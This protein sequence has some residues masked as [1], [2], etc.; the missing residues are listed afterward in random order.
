[1]KPTMKATTRRALD[2]IDDALADYLKISGAA[3]ETLAS[4]DGIAFTMRLM[5][6]LSENWQDCPVKRCR[7]ARCCQGPDMVCQ[8]DGFPRLNAPPA[9]IARANARMR[10]V[11]VW[12]LEGFGLL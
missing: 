3:P 9:E 6:D 8:L 10:R 5:S 1:M 4:E 7:R 11:A 2:R 12:H